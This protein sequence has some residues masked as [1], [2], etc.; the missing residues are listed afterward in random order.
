[1]VE[2][3]SSPRIVGAGVGGSEGESEFWRKL[4]KLDC[5]PKVK[6]FL[7]RLCH[8]MLAVRRILKRSGM[9]IDTRCCM[10]NRLDEDGG[11]LL[12][13]C[14]EVKQ[15]WRELNLESVRS[16]LIEAV[17]PMQM[18]ERVMELEEK[19]K[20][21]VIRLLWLWWG[22][23]NSFRGVQRLATEVAFITALQA[24][25]FQTTKISSLNREGRVP[26]ICQ[27]YRWLKPPKGVLKINSDG[28]FKCN[29]RTGGWGFVIRDDRGAVVKAGAAAG[30]FLTDAFHAE[31]LGF[32]AGLKKLQEWALLSMHR[33]RCNHGEGGSGGR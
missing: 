22:E 12:L 3:R 25:K 31:L 11:H 19:K 21:T 18:M 9:E 24:D 15:V 7:W 29:E 28:A 23:L 1:M 27:T 8:N 13:K 26:E 30:H 17:S 4:W 6:H 32:L 2:S 33:N 20:L 14:K 10:C 5:P 16:R